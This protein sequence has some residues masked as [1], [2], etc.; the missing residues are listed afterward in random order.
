ML[1][2]EHFSRRIFLSVTF[3]FLVH[4]SVGFIPLIFLFVDFY[5]EVFHDSIS[6]YRS[7]IILVVVSTSKV[8]RVYAL[9]IK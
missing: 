1:L 8:W 3:F 6:R 5:R 7:I 2:F 9:C 4:S